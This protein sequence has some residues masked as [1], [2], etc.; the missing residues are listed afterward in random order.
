M[1]FLT[2]PLLALAVA[3][4]SLAQAP[5]GAQLIATKKAAK[6]GK[7]GLMIRVRME[8]HQGEAKTTRLVQIKRRVLPDGHSEQLYQVTF[9]K[10]QKG[11]ALLLRTS[12]KGFTGTLFTPGKET[13]KLGDAD[14]SMSLFDTDMTLED[15]LK[16]VTVGQETLHGVPCSI[17]ES[18]PASGGRKVKTWV[19][20]KRY[21]A[22]RIQLFAQG[23]EPVRV[24]ETNKVMRGESGYYFPASFTISTPAKGSETVVEG[25]GSSEQ[26]FTDA[27]FS[28]AALQG[29]SKAP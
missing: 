22:Q 24:V 26:A 5:T 11:T 25:T 8:Q 3:T 23:S 18:R 7:G 16:H 29:Q 14:R 19:D 4:I 12:A 27:D 1:R 28:E 10:E 13:R 15:A 9:P 6:P 17:I 2:V 20:E 21:V